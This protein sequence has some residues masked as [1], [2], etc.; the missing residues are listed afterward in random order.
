L[1]AVFYDVVYR[2]KPK[3]TSLFLSILLSQNFSPPFFMNFPSFLC[4]SCVYCEY[5]IQFFFFNFLLLDIKTSRIT[6]PLLNVVFFHFSLS[7]VFVRLL[8][9]QKQISTLKNA[10]STKARV[11]ELYLFRENF[12]SCFYRDGD[13]TLFYEHIHKIEIF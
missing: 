7:F 4:R 6:A 5:K 10:C 9:L 12:T 11:L 1:S 2:T 13:F 3:L 8:L